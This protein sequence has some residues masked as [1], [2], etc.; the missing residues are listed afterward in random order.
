MRAKCIAVRYCPNPLGIVTAMQFDKS[1]FGG[2]SPRTMLMAVLGFIS[3]LQ[4]VNRKE[5]YSSQEQASSDYTS[6]LCSHL[7]LR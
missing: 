5:A 2:E 7:P 3:Y 1:E 6:F 4:E